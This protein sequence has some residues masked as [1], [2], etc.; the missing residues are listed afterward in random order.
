MGTST[1]SDAV[2]HQQIYE[3]ERV[4]AFILVDSNSEYVAPR[5][6]QFG[7][8]GNYKFAALPVKGIWDGNHVIPDDDTD[9]I[10]N[11]NQLLFSQHIDGDNY[12]PESFIALQKSLHDNPVMTNWSSS[13]EQ[14]RFHL[15]AIKEETLQLLFELPNVTK[16][17]I[18]TDPVQDLKIADDMIQKLVTIFKEN[19]SWKEDKD[20]RL[21]AAILGKI[22]GFE[23]GYHPDCTP[24]PLASRAFQ[25]GSGS[26]M[27]FKLWHLGNDCNLIGTELS[28]YIEEH[29]KKPRDYDDFFTALH[30]CIAV[31]EAL[32]ATNRMLSPSHRTR[33]LGLDLSNTDI[34]LKIIE[35]ELLKHL[36]YCEKYNFHDDPEVEIRLNKIKTLSSLLTNRHKDIAKKSQNQN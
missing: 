19:P 15:M 24:V 31:N 3:N 25:T 13:S 6:M 26:C 21:D 29:Q 28:A 4:I 16:L 14:S 18:Q 20:T 33:G 23:L 7:E 32:V 2:T 22:I 5:L 35:L 8:T 10:A 30:Q 9:F 11:F 12:S 27:A 1:I 36:D 34:S 17:K